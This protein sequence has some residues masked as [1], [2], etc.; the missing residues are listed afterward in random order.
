MPITDTRRLAWSKTESRR[1]AEIT[2]AGI[3][4]AMTTTIAAAVSSRV[5][6]RNSST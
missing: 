1:T 5:A 3:P 2:P 4:I 6:G